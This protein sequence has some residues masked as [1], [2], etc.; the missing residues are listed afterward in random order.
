MKGG[1]ATMSDPRSHMTAIIATMK[2]RTGR[3]LE[4][5]VEKAK[6]EIPAEKKG[7]LKWIKEAYGLEQSTAYMILDA[8]ENDG[9]DE[10]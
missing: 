9:Q 1:N 4:E 3:T 7:R 5:W 2:N 6:K 10:R 8:L